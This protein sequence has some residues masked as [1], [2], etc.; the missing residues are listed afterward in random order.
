M[1]LELHPGAAK[2]EGAK[3]HSVEVELAVLTCY[4]NVSS[5]VK[6]NTLKK[7]NLLSDNTYSSNSMVLNLNLQ[8]VFF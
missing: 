7:F 4:S 2:G 8:S 5:K 3:R 1:L 6:Q